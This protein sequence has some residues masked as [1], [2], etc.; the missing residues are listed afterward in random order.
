MCG[1]AGIWRL[2][3]PRPGDGARLA[4]MADTLV[5]RGPDD[6]GYLLANAASGQSHI[7]QDT[8]ADRDADVLLASRRLSIIDLSTRGRQPIANETGD[9]FVVFNGA[10]HNYV[11]LR[12]ELEALGH[13]FRS[14]TDT[15]VI[16]HAYEEWG[17]ACAG[18]FNGM[19]AYVIWDS[20]RRRLVCSRDRF[21][22]KPLYIARRGDTFFFASEAKA[23]L[24]SG[25]VPATPNLEFLSRFVT[26]RTPA[27]GQQSAFADIAQVP[28]AHNLVLTRDGFEET[29]YWSYGDQSESYDFSRPEATFRALLDDSIRLRRRADVPLA[30]LLS[31]GLDSS[32][33]LAL[34]AQQSGAGGMEAFTATF[35]GYEHDERRHAETMAAAAGIKLN[36]VECGADN[37]MEDLDATTWHMDCPVSQGQVLS[38]WRLLKAVSER[39]RVV[40]E[41]QGAD[42]MLA[43]YPHLYIRAYLRA[44]LEAMTPWSAPRRLKRI[45]DTFTDL[46]PGALRREFRRRFRRL[47]PGVAILSK[48]FSGA[49]R[50]PRDPKGKDAPGF[51]DPLKRIL[52]RHHAVRM[53]PYLLHFGDAISMAHSVESRLP[54]LD[55]RLVE[56][57]FALPFDMLMRGGT[58][59]HV[60]REALAADLPPAICRRRDKVGFATPVGAWLRPLFKEV[61][62]PTLTSRRFRER[63]LFNPSGIDHLLDQFENAGQ[64]GQDLFRCLAIERWYRQFV[65]GDGRAYGESFNRLNVS[66][67]RP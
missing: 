23:I 29:A 37:F 55:H 43:G 60:L 66:P 52:H 53:L 9:V 42:E 20:R 44:E 15:E 33:I 39:A 61:V 45:R 27:E 22:I 57:S 54:F 25:E 17:E 19:W 62:R 67:N 59:K 32:S 1:I 12:R 30:V 13:V 5:H 38:R 3:G 56:F 7:S 11:E 6:F 4:R 63:G 46:N 10:I 26:S 21:G 48:D 41:G 64:G 49:S 47:K 16:V 65:D 18:R 28:A 34:A 58:T 8:A 2:G 14:K 36:L 51:S 35:P 31:G 40:F 24:A 50:I